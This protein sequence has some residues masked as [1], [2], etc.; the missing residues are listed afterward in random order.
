MKRLAI[1]ILA[2][3]LLPLFANGQA[4]E[5]KT[6]TIKPKSTIYTANFKEFV[7]TEQDIIVDPNLFKE[8]KISKQTEYEVLGFIKT[9]KGLPYEYYVVQHKDITCYVS[10]SS[11]QDNTLM[12]E[13]NHTLA[14]EYAQL[15]NEVSHQREN[16]DSILAYKKREIEKAL[17][18]VGDHERRRSELIDSLYYAIKEEHQ[19]TIS[20]KYQKW[21]DSLSPSAKIAASIIAIHEST[22][23]SP[24][25]VSGCDYD[26]VYTNMSPKTIKYL[27]WYGNIYNAVG[28][29]IECETRRT[30]SFSGKD[31]GPYK[32]KERGG[33]TWEHVIYNWSAKEMRL[34]KI[35]I[36]YMDG[37]T[38]SIAAKDIAELIGAP[39]FYID[40]AHDYSEAVRVFNNQ[41]KNEK[42]VWTERQK[43]LD[44]YYRS[45]L[46][47]DLENYYQ[48]AIDAELKLEAAIT[49]LNSYKRNHLIE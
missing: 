19:N 23:G 15:L 43:F 49:S 10:P 30:Y 38:F 40:S 1:T 8:K 36:E 11:V 39:L 29:K 34:S 13:T 20:N 31:T 35:T 48:D 16:R 4:I 46:H 47:S 3:V 26:L 37:S 6:I 44:K 32:N 33:G 18:I 27:Y 28:D 24:N 17:K 42:T 41:L 22:L 9:Q 14:K 25:S 21:L 2:F 45:Y 12:E 5:K 7:N